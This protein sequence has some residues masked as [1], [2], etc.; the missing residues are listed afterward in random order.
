ML[1]DQGYLDDLLE[2][3]QSGIA[4]YCDEYLNAEI[5]SNHLDRPEP[6]S[7]KELCRYLGVGESTMTG[8]IKEDRIPLMAKEAFLLPLALR[9]LINEIERLRN[10]AR[11]ARILKSGDIYQICVF[12]PDECGE[13]IGKVVADN[14]IDP[15]NARLI[16]TGVKA[17]SILGECDKVVEQMQLI[18]SDGINPDYDDDLHELREKIRMSRLYTG[19]YKLWRKMKTPSEPIDFDLSCLK[20][21]GEQGNTSGT[22]G[23]EAGGKEEEKS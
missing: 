2:L 7:R 20:D 5:L 21:I 13:V 23:Q 12:Q 6:F 11:Q 3:E 14:I 8:W 1:F 19:D 22:S 17:L 10:D 4:E 18:E 16:L 9:V 15:Q